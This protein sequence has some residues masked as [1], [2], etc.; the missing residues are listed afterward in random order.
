MGNKTNPPNPKVKPIG[1]LPVKISLEVGLREYLV[2]HSQIFKM[3]L[4]KC[5]VILGNPVVPEV[6]PMSA[7]LSLL[8]L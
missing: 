4:W 7:T 6:N 3:S 5:E 2:K 8:V 1:G